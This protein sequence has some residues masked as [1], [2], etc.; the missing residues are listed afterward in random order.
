MEYEEINTDFRSTVE[1]MF[2]LMYDAGG[3]GLAAPQ[4]G[5]SKRFF[6]MDV[7]QEDGS[8]NPLV[9]INPEIIAVEGEQPG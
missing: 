5:I 3:V 6:I 7:P 2:R 4:V 9:F 1:E 8:P